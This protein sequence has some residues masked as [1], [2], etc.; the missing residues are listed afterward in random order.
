MLYNEYSKRLNS[1]KVVVTGGNGFI[2]RH[3]VDRLINLNFKVT[4]LDRLNYSFSDDVNFVLGDVRNLVTVESLLSSH[5]GVIN[6]Q[7]Y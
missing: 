6:L 4:V 3:V 5:D 1:G 2:G 7:V